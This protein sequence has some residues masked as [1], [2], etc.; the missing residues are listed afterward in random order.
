M[1]FHA[2][3]DTKASPD[4]VL[5]AFTDFTD[6]RPVIW[7]GTLDPG[8][9]EVYEVGDTWADVR[10]GSK[11][12]EVWAV[13]HYDWSEPGRIT[14]TAKESNFCQPGSGVE[15]YITESDAGGSHIELDWHRKPRNLKGWLLI[16]MTKVIGPRKLGKAWGEALDRYAETPPD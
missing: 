8:K 12:P 7:E 11:R 5:A 6:R 2:S 4:Q 13:E 9:Y 1:Q 16:P 15:L 14:W 10:E 3:L